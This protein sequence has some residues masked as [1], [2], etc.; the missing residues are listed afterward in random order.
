MT[1]QTATEVE[2]VSI[3]DHDVEKEESGTN[4]L[5]IFENRGDSAV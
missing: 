3:G 5:C 4:S 2:A 1:A